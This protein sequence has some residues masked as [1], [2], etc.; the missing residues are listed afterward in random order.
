[1]DWAAIA[2]IGYETYIRTRQQSVMDPG[3]ISLGTWDSLP[4][5]ARL[6]WIEAAKE[7]TREAILR[8]PRRGA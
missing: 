3:F 7:I 2:R 4:V 8:E 6:G 1:M 5:S